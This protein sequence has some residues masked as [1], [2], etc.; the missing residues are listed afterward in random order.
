MRFGAKVPTKSFRIVTTSW[1]DGDLYDLRVAELLHTRKLAG[2]FYIPI[3]GH[4]S[5]S[6]MAH[7]DVRILWSQGFEIGAHGL[8]HLILSD[9]NQKEVT[10]EVVN[11]KMRLEELLGDRVRM[12][13]YPRGRF[14]TMAIRSVKQ[15][16]YTGARTTQMLVQ[17]FSFDPYRMPTTVHVYPHS[18][19]EYVRNAA[20][21]LDFG[22][23]WRCLTRFRQIENWVELGKLLF[24]SVLRDGGIWHLYGHSWEIEEHNLWSGLEEILDYVC[25]REDVLYLTNGH[26]LDCVLAQNVPVKTGPNHKRLRR[27]ET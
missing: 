20:R 26:T 12:F 14:S 17:G 3:A 8:S 5:S 21:A 25:K 19:S 24:D 23:V 13:A 9:C 11:C 10:Q 1:D 16:G 27:S 4:H 2:T 15:A 6:P 18:R 22:C 7:R